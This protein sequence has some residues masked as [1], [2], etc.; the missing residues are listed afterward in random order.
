MK[1]TTKNLNKNTQNTTNNSTSSS[2]PTKKITRTTPTER[3]L[4]MGRVSEGQ[5]FKNFCELCKALRIKKEKYSNRNCRPFIQKEMARYFEYTK[6]GHAITI[7]KIYDKP[8]KK[9]SKIPQ[10]RY[11]GNTKLI[12]CD[13]LT[14]ISE[15]SS[16]S[17]RSKISVALTMGEWQ[18][19]IGFSS[20]KFFDKS[21]WK[22]PAKRKHMTNQNINE[23]YHYTKTKL[24]TSLLSVL[25]TLQNQNVISY[26]QKYILYLDNGEKIL[27]TP[28]I[29]EAILTAEKN[30]LSTLG[31]DNISFV[32]RTGQIDDFYAMVIDNVKKGKNAIPLFSR[33]YKML[34]IEFYRPKLKKTLSEDEKGKD[35]LKLIKKNN[36]LIIESIT[37]ALNKKIN[38][39]YFPFTQEQTKYMIHALLPI[40]TEEINSHDYFDSLLIDEPIITSKQNKKNIS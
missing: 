8:L 14:Y 23:F 16:V 10:G 4:C 2:K 32:Y 35:I 24:R 38:E 20:A 19:V 30:T 9:E 21:S 15:N 6:S 18:Q 25:K 28:E 31:Y 34:E 11:A 40:D 12:L 36:G 29:T 33:Y 17:K 3:I 7:T 39:M 37:K 1:N 26:S 5:T 27:S 22:E 13:F